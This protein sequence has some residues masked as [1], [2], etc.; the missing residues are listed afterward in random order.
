MYLAIYDYETQNIGDIALT[1]GDQIDRVKD[2]GCGWMIGHNITTNMTGHFPAAYVQL[3][4]EW[5]RR[6]TSITSRKKNSPKNDTTAQMPKRT[7]PVPVNEKHNMEPI[8]DHIMLKSSEKDNLKRRSDTKLVKDKLHPLERFRKKITPQDK[9]KRRRLNVALGFGTGL[10]LGTVLFFALFY[11]FH[12]TLLVS[13]IITGVSTFLLCVGLAFSS[14]CRCIILLVLP[15][16]ATGKGRAAFLSLITGFLLMGPVM[17]ITR[18][19]NEVAASMACITELAYN[20]SQVLQDALKKPLEEVEEQVKE[21]VEVVKAYASE[22]TRELDKARNALMSAENTVTDVVNGFKNK[23]VSSVNSGLNECMR[24]SKKL[25]QDCHRSLDPF[26]MATKDVKN[27]VNTVTDFFRGRRRRDAFSTN[28]YLDLNRTK[29]QSGGIGR[30]CDIFFVGD[31]ICGAFKTINV[32][33]IVSFPKDIISGAFRIFNDAFKF[34]A[35]LLDVDFISSGQIDSG[36]NAS[37]SAAQIISNIRSELK[38]KIDKATY[39]INILNRVVS[40]SVILLIIN[41]FLY[42]RQYLSKISFDN[43]YITSYFKIIDRQRKDNGKISI[44]PLKKKER[45][46]YTESRSFKMS[47]IELTRCKTGLAQVLLHAVMCV[48]LVLFD[49]LLYYILDLLNRHGD[50]QFV[51]TGQ[52]K[53]NIQITGKGPIALLFKTLTGDIRVSQTYNSVVDINTCLPKPKDP[54]F[55]FLYV[56]GGL[57]MAALLLVFLQG[58]GKR[59]MYFIAAFFYPEKEQQ[60]VNYLY[61]RILVKRKVFLKEAK[62]M[63]LSNA[64]GSNFDDGHNLCGGLASRFPFCRKSN[65]TCTNCEVSSEDISACR[66][67]K[68]G[69]FYC[70]ECF[71]EFGRSCPLCTNDE[72]DEDVYEVLGLRE[73]TTRAVKSPDLP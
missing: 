10:L 71:V 25:K 70:E 49:Y 36:A 50:V 38:S 22:I 3:S 69:A 6:L 61:R 42:E 8:K 41:A 73:K 45:K 68:C 37:Q 54:N 2:V 5:K 29:R 4:S 63:I 9:I 7:I 23:C 55:S 51:F 19:A 33:S 11:S 17:N 65:K 40:L 24:G 16:L 13:G 27:L 31:Q 34:Y 30:I 57:Y 1:K 62:Q 35:E 43:F 60:R 52:S 18:N 72:D 26:K 20:Q 59:L 46:I 15:S 28:G 67:E 53:L 21:G 32:C 14:R 64:V 66:N 48:M 39:Y 56:F 44:L 12:Y 58:Y 47:S